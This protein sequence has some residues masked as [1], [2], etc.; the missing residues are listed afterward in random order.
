MTAKNKH[1]TQDDRTEIQECLYKGMTFKAIAKRI[2]K[3]STTISKEVRLHARLRR[4]SSP[5]R[6]VLVFFIG[7]PPISTTE[8]L[9]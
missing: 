3:D 9:I 2:G 5:G 7:L 6:R 1:M 8:N 4:L